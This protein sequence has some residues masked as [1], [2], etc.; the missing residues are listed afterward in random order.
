MVV[1]TQGHLIEC[2][3]YC[4]KTKTVASKDYWL[5]MTWLEKAETG[6]NAN[7]KD[8]FKHQRS[9]PEFS[10]QQHN[11]T[12]QTCQVL[13]ERKPLRL[14]SHPGV[15]LT[16][17]F[18][19]CRPAWW[20]H[21]QSLTCPSSSLTSLFDSIFSSSCWKK[22]SKGRREEKGE[23]E[24]REKRKKKKEFPEGLRSAGPEGLPM[25]HQASS[26]VFGWGESGKGMVSHVGNIVQGVFVIYCCVTN[27]P[28]I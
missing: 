6:G 18:S 16:S 13:R 8:Y 7:Q 2:F 17:I 23:K 22:N 9:F 25:W 5:Q 3:L 27:Y 24:K 15:F 11:W 10:S 20:F 19:L 28:N 21:P 14:G 4:Q 12:C 1:Q 26:F